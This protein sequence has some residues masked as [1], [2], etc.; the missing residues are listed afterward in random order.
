MVVL[1]ELKILSLWIIGHEFLICTSQP[2]KN[3]IFL[4]DTLE[5]DI[6][7]IKKAV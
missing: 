4:P 3:F 7:I 1:C 2:L 5:V 6:Q